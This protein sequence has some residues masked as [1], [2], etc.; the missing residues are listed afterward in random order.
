MLSVDANVSVIGVKNRIPVI[1]VI[2]LDGVSEYTRGCCIADTTAH[3]LRAY[4]LFGGWTRLSAFVF[5]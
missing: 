4:A 5:R 3:C 2:P 1:N